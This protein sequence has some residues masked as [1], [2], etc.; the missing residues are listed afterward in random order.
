MASVT[1]CPAVATRSAFVAPRSSLPV[2]RL[3]LRGFPRCT[4]LRLRPCGSLRRT[5]PH[6]LRSSS[7]RGSSRISRSLA[8]V[9]GCRP[10]LLGFVRAFAP[11]PSIDIILGVCAVRGVATA[12]EGGAEPRLA[13]DLAVSHSLAGLLRQKTRRLVASCCRS[14]G[15]IRFV[16]PP[17]GASPRSFVIADDVPCWSPRAGVPASRFVPPEGVPSPAAVSH[18]C[19]RCLLGLFARRRSATFVPAAVSSFGCS[20][21]ID[22]RR[23]LE[24]LLRVRVRTIGHLVQVAVGLSFLGLGPLRGCRSLEPCGSSRTS[25]AP[26]VTR[27]LHVRVPPR[28]WSF[29]SLLVPAFAGLDETCSVPCPL[30]CA[31]AARSLIFGS[32]TCSSSSA[33]SKPMKPR[34]SGRVRVVPAVAGGAFAFAGVRLPSLSR[35]GHRSPSLVRCSFGHRGWR[36]LRGAGPE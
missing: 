34:S 14:W 23:S 24:A 31:L 15:S 32:S 16:H 36:A 3:D 20:G 7:G 9:G 22:G 1:R 29:R 12:S 5:V 11:F 18:R 2:A 13:S 6:G 28:S 17:G 25:V 4:V 27:I 26:S 19:D 35:A 30:S 10:T 8:P 33:S 21:R